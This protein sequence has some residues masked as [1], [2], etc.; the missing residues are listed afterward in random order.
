MFPNEEHLSKRLH[1]FALPQTY[2][3]GVAKALA[4]R[5]AVEKASPVF[6]KLR[7]DRKAVCVAGW[8]GCRSPLSGS[9]LIDPKGRVIHA[10]PCPIHFSEL[11]FAVGRIT[12]NR[13]SRLVAAL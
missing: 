7:T 10:E 5:A 11:D 2:G 13:T 3:H 9:R 6:G 12:A 4:L 1:R 8:P